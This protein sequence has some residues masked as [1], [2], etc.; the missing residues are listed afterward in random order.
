MNRRFKPMTHALAAAFVVLL[1]SSGAKAEYPEGWTE[2]ELAL[3]P[4][5]CQDVQGLKWGDAYYHTSPNA[6]KWIAVMGNGFWA[7]HHYCWASINLLRAERPSTPPQERTRLR[8]GAIA[9]MMYVVHNTPENFVL[10]PEIYTRKGEVELKLKRY[11]DA[12]A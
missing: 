4:P 11:A 9:D 12:E 3:A 1:A 8:A 7:V 5:F 10:L 6:K 2:S